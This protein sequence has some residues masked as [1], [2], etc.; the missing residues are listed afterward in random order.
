MVQIEHFTAPQKLPNFKFSRRAN[1]PWGTKYQRGKKIIV[2][3]I[4]NLF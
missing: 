1:W 2:N 4:A 3:Q